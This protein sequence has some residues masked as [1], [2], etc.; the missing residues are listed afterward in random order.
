MLQFV[1]LMCVIK[2]C[3]VHLYVA[4]SGTP[5]VDTNTQQPPRLDDA[6]LNQRFPSPEVLVSVIERAQQLLGGSAASA[7]SV[8]YPLW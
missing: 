8:C 7:L 5:S 3:H 2:Y 1:S 6:Y 4:N